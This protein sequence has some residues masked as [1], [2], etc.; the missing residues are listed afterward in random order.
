MCLITIVSENNRV[1]FIKKNHNS[2]LRP[3]QIMLR[4]QITT[5]N[6]TRIVAYLRTR[7]Q[8]SKY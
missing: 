2:F 3:L 8:D 5:W 4:T 6:N 1:L 7:I